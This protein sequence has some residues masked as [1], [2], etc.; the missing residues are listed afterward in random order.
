M[1]WC[2]I[3]LCVLC[4]LLIPLVIKFDGE[5]TKSCSNKVVP[6]SAQNCHDEACSRNIRRHTTNIINFFMAPIV[7][8]CYHTVIV[9]ITRKSLDSLRDMYMNTCLRLRSY[10]HT[11]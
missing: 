2:Q 11:H 5:S 8:F 6:E 1:R 10:K 4:P 7:K 9:Y 3:V